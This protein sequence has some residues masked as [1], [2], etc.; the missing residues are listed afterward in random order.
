MPLAAPVIAPFRFAV[1]EQGAAACAGCN[2]HGCNVHGCNVHGCNVHGCNVH[3]CNVHGCNVQ[4]A[5]A[6][7]HPLHSALFFTLS[8][9][10]YRSAYPTIKNFRFLAR[11]RLR[12]ILSLTPGAVHTLRL[13]L[14]S[15]HS[16]ILHSLSSSC[17]A[18]SPRASQ[19]VPV[20]PIIIMQPLPSRDTLPVLR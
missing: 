7:Q 16:A 3:G 19:C 1:V 11:L 5:R 13:C 15:L 6:L 8:A 12:C 14:Q 9:G 18:T 10:L 17:R 4:H 2:V 20:P